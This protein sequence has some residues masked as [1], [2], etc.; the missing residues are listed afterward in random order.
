MGRTYFFFFSIEK[1]RIIIANV[2]ENNFENIWKSL[3]KISENIFEK[4]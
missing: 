1:L 4:L 2:L 3:K